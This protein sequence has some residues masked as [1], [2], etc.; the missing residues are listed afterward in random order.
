M[1]H[2]MR[3]GKQ[4]LSNEKCNEILDR[5]TSGVLSLLGLDGYPYGVPLSYVHNNGRIIFHGALTGHK[6]E[7]IRHC[8]KASFCVIDQDEVVPE[9]FTTRYRSVIAFG[10]VRL[11]DDPVE[12]V[13]KARILT[14]KYSPGFMDKA[15][16]TIQSA[17]G[18]MSVFEL[19][20]ERLTGKSS[21]Q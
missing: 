3:R 20:I 12:I 16:A 9:K 18:R 14:Q 13:A 10:K 1:D 7:A 15:D 8:D 21:L 5:N 6:I 19:D 11:L 2:K 4:Q 17:K